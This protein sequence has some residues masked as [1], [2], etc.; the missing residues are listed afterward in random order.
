MKSRRSMYI[1]ILIFLT[2]IYCTSSYY[3]IDFVLSSNQNRQ[4]YSELAAMVENARPEAVATE[5]EPEE[6]IP[7]ESAPILTEYSALYQM[8]TDMVGWLE[9]PGTEINYPVMQTPDNKDYYLDHDFLREE[10]KFGCLYA[11]EACSVNPP[12]DNITVFGHHMRDGS[13]FAPLSGYRSESF[14]QSHEL[15]QFDSL[16]LRRT[17]RIFAVFTTSGTSGDGFA[18]HRFVDAADQAEFDAFITSCK[19]LS[20]Y[21]TGITPVYGDQII[22]LSTCEYTQDNG[23]L[24]VAAVRIS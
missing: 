15:I 6:P 17:Y 9:I 4:R 22:C 5:S 14:Y 11:W 1:I 12:S 16:T 13:M 18:Y 19:A 2:V 7:A 24:V 21:D 10:S 23:R 20:L 8:N 3:V